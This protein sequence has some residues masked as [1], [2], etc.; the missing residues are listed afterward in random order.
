ME[1]GLGAPES[2]RFRDCWTALGGGESRA[3]APR[4]AEEAC[5]VTVS[6]D[7]CCTLAS[8]LNCEEDGGGD[9]GGEP[10]MLKLKTDID[11]LEKHENTG[12]TAQER[13]RKQIT[14]RTWC[15]GWRAVPPRLDGRVLR[16]TQ[17]TQRDHLLV[18]EP[19]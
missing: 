14:S 10:N 18:V 6:T 7:N 5:G 17:R 3:S 19:G 4:L 1:G 12:I 9:A 2:D 13:D 16:Y 8:R 15:H 11:E